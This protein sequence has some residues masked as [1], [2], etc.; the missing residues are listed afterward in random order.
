[1][2]FVCFSSNRISPTKYKIDIYINNKNIQIYYNSFYRKQY[3]KK[4][5][6]WNVSN[7]YPIS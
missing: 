7:T 4:E 2:V 5:T 3:H 1:M 6:K